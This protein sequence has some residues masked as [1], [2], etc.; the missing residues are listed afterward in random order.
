MIEFSSFNYDF[1][2]HQ[3]GVTPSLRSLSLRDQSATKSKTLSAL[4]PSAL[5]DRFKIAVI[6]VQKGDWSMVL[7]FINTDPELL[8]M[9]SS[10][11]NDQSLLH[12]VVAQRQYVPEK[13]V[14]LMLNAC[15]RIIYAVDATLCTS[16]HYV[17][18]HGVH[19][20]LLPILLERWK[21]GAS[22]ANL[23]GNLPLHLA[24]LGGRRYVID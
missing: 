21:D 8:L 19:A 2:F 15:P 17:A 12:I 14:I 1:V 18:S 9:R 11:R 23:D 4:F 6:A 16:L 3:P 20:D 13:V 24:A 7:Q 5:Q 22:E 10:A